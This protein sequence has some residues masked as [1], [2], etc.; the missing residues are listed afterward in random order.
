[1]HMYMHT[2]RFSK[3]Q[4]ECHRPLETDSAKTSVVLFEHTACSLFVFSRNTQWIPVSRQPAM[5]L[6]GAS[7]IPLV[8]LVTSFASLVSL[9][10]QDLEQPIRE[11]C[12]SLQL[13]WNPWIS[14]ETSSTCAKSCSRAFGGWKLVSADSRRAGWRQ[15]GVSK[16]ALK[17]GVCPLFHFET[18]PK[19]VPSAHTNDVECV[20]LLARMT[21]VRKGWR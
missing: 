6:L 8:F 4:V 18:A 10:N 15:M 12:R 11:P 13:H 17:V 5:F 20:C 16:W 21:M 1:M 14:K 3:D 2:S 9:A 7:G 19:N